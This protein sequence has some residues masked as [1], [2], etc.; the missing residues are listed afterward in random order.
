MSPGSGGTRTTSVFLCDVV[1][2]HL[3]FFALQN[4]DQKINSVI[5]Q[6]GRFTNEVI[7]PVLGQLGTFLSCSPTDIF[8]QHNTWENVDDTLVNKT[9]QC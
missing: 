6:E 5:S 4:L 8:A 2:S 7:D 3:Y 1:V 9:F